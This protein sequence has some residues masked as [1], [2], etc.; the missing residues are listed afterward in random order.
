MSEKEQ[1]RLAHRM[2]VLNESLAWLSEIDDALEKTMD[3]SKAGPRDTA[4]PKEGPRETVS[5]EKPRSAAMPK[6]VRDEVA[7]KGRQIE[8]K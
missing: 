7:R 3:T 8:T 5:T 1:Q 6:K 4:E 2:D